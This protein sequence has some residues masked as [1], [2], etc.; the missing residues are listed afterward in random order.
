MRPVA[1]ASR[2]GGATRNER[3]LRGLGDRGGGGEQRR[4]GEDR[5][6][7]AGECERDRER[8]LREAGEQQHAAALEAVGDPARERRHG[9]HGRHRRR[10]QRGHGERA[11]R[12]LVDLQG[13]RDDRDHVAGGREAGG[14][15]QQAEVAPRAQPELTAARHRFT[16]PG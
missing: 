6:E 11:A 3:E 8:R 15:R 1:A 13:E 4:E 9:H 2:S 10:E 16:P 14:E 12:E 7:V 5:R